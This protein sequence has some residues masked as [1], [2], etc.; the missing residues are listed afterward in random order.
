MP[1]DIKIRTSRLVLS[2]VTID[3]TEQVHELLSV[4]EVDR[5][6]ALGIP[7]NIE[8]TS[9]YV[10][11]WL[12]DQQHRTQLVFSI[13]LIQEDTFIGVLGIKLSH[14]K[15][16]RGEV[17]YKIH[18]TFW[19]KGYATECLRGALQCCFEEL[20]LHRIEAGCAIENVASVKVLEKNGMIREGRKRKNLP[21]ISG[22]S[23]TYQYGILAEDW[24]KKK[25]V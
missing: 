13:R 25:E 15:Y 20:D 10:E 5:Y 9:V 4:P 24:A 23:D 16:K 21:L 1:L 19:N 2:L 11:E 17:W 18:P 7:T 8:V 12:R 22:W 6:N 14:F 3:E